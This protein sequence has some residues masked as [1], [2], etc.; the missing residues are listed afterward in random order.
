M[1]KLEVDGQQPE[2]KYLQ[3]ANGIVAQIE[4]GT[5]EVNDRLPSVNKLSEELS[6]SRET[7]FKALNYLSAQGVVHSSNRKGYY[8]RRSDVK[9]P[10]RIFLLFDKMTPFKQKIYQAFVDQ[11]GQAGSV[12][13]FFHHHNAQIFKSL[14]TQNLSNYTHYVV[15]TFL[16]EPCTEILNLI[17]PEKRLIL[18]NFEKGLKGKPRILYQDFKR[19][20]YE[21]LSSITD[22]LS[23]YQQLVMIAPSS[24]YHLD[25]AIPGFISFCQDHQFNGEVVEGITADDIQAGTV[26]LSL[27]SDD[28]DLVNIIKICRAKN[29]EIGQQIGIISYNDTAVKEILAGGITV[30][31]TD[32]AYMGKKAAEMIQQRTY[33]IFPNPTKLIKRGSL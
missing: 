22:P 17:P 12:D 5:L 3:I 9:L 11:V 7:V 15:V 31:T 24:L 19:D 30:I 20:I 25:Q 6:V 27:R 29:L 23:R 1:L 32:F 2:P 28:D 4:A 21:A 8:V 14:I 18:D 26:Y 16:K 13:I 10:L 33:G